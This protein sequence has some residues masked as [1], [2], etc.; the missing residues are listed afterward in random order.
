LIEDHH[1]KLIEALHSLTDIAEVHVAKMKEMDER[2]RIE[3]LSRA[4]VCDFPTTITIPLL[5]C[6][7]RSLQILISVHNDK[8]LQTLWMPATPISSLIEIFDEGGF[9]RK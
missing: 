7:T 6:A 1:D 2:T 8:L 5:I 9:A 3:L 4:T